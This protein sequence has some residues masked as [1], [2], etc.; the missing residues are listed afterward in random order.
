MEGIEVIE[1]GVNSASMRVSARRIGT[2]R[3]RFRGV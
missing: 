3:L 2:S 1:A